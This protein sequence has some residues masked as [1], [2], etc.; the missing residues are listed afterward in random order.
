PD[1]MAEEGAEQNA[2]S[3]PLEDE[4]FSLAR[5]AAADRSTPDTPDDKL[6]IAVM[7]SKG[8]LPDLDR[9]LALEIRDPDTK[10]A[11]LEERTPRVNGLRRLL[12]EM[13]LGPARIIRDH[14][15]QMTY[16][17]PLREIPTRSYRPQVTPDGARWA[18]GL[19]AWDL[20]YT[21]RSGD[22]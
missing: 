14:L 1:D 8:A 17:G 19:A 10:K 11:E 3:S 22:L 15:R 4:I 9:E 16:I 2:G 20:L 21:T 18:H 5:E 7:T 6:R 13:V 12:S